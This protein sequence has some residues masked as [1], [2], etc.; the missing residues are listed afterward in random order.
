MSDDIRE[1]LHR[2]R[3]EIEEHN[4]RYYE[5]AAPTISDAEFDALLRE[6]GLDVDDV[7]R[8]R[9]GKVIV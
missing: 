4:R 2:L 3:L 6:L 9:E 1:R 8:L 7:A 5:E